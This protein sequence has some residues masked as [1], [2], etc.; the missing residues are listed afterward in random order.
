MTCKGHCQTS[1]LRISGVTTNP[2]CD[3]R[4]FCYFS[5]IILIF[6]IVCSWCYINFGIRVRLDCFLTQSTIYR[7]KFPLVYHIAIYDEYPK[8]TLLRWQPTQP[9]TMRWFIAWCGTSTGFHFLSDRF[10]L[11]TGRC[12]MGSTSWQTGVRR[13]KGERRKERKWNTTRVWDQW[14]N[15]RSQH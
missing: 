10:Y 3:F 15:T 14:R 1:A 2:S 5:L 7:A 12:H 9:T 6:P 8:R 13:R 11:K 4:S